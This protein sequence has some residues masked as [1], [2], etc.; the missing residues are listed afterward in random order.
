MKKTGYWL[1]VIATAV[2]LI[3]IGLFKFTPTEAK[4]IKQPL[5]FFNL[6]A[7]FLIKNRNLT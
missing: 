7:D 3:W 5:T 6:R 1:S 4:A 2:V